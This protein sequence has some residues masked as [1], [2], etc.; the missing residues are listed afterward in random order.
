L[1]TSRIIFRE[2][3]LSQ[4]RST[5]F[6][7]LGIEGAAFLLC[8][9]AQGGGLLKLISNAVVPVADEDYLTRERDRLSIGSRALARITKRARFEKLSVIFAHSHPFGPA[10]FSVQD[11]R[12]EADL[13][14]FLQAR[15]P[16]RLHG[17]VVLTPETVTGRIFEFGDFGRSTVDTITSIGT[18]VRVLDSNT[19]SSPSPFFDRQIRA[20]GADSQAIL[21][22]LSVGV[23]G[24]GGTGSPVAEQLY[25]LGVGEL[26]LVD[27]D[28]LEDSN[29]NRV[30]GAKV[31]DVGRYKVDIAKSRL[32][33]IGFDTPVRAVAEHI[34]WEAS[35]RQ[36]TGCDIVF[37]CVDK[38]LPRA[39]LNQMALLYAIPTF[40]L[41]VLL[42][43][44]AGELQGVHGRVTTLLP[45]EAC[46][47]CRG[48]ISVQAMQAEAM[49]AADRRERI[50]E[51]YAPDLD[52][53]AP[54]VIAFTSA[55]A[56][57][58]VLE[59]LHRITGF[60]GDDRDS[61]E[62]LIR[63]DQSKVR[64]NR[65]APADTCTCGREAQFGR[66]DQQPFLGMV[67]PTRTK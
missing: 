30:Y 56:S 60:M 14:P 44:R 41:G 46:L 54:A 5:L 35:A 17:T 39:I 3:H 12:E 2:E 28:R 65:I 4:L 10:D 25:R 31:S 34:T 1:T 67:W 51:G 50:K 16:E 29:L 22:A 63:F 53:P 18:R 23:V 26:V 36:L 38:Q 15:L 8:G 6:G 61:T 47:L 66:G 11:D 52:D 7:K 45:G 27:G 21:R 37:A 43:S 49:S 42:D 48:R 19:S 57:F 55:V 32:D 62:L 59:F 9:E 13:I 33:E 64:T 24:L 40:D 20:F 58:A